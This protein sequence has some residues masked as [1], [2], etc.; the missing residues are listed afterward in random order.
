MPFDG[1]LQLVLLLLLLRLLALEGS[2][3]L[4]GVLNQLINLHQL[5]LNLLEHPFRARQRSLAFLESS[6]GI[7]TG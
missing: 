4:Y 6:G 3:A 1:P 2:H 5:A 7:T